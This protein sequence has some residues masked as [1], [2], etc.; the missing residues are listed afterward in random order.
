MF[1]CVKLPALCSEGKQ[2]SD[3]EFV[4]HFSA[5]VETVIRVVL[6]AIQCLVERKQEDG[7]EEEKSLEESGKFVNLLKGEEEESLNYANLRIP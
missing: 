2:Q 6:Y 5:K 3:E 1:F 4:E 7:K